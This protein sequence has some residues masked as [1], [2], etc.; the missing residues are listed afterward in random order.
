MRASEAIAAAF[1]EGDGDGEGEGE[2]NGGEGGGEV[3]GGDGDGDGELGEGLQAAGVGVGE[4]E[5]GWLPAKQVS[6]RLCHCTQTNR[7]MVRREG[8]TTG[9]CSQKH[10]AARVQQYGRR[11]RLGKHGA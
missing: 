11:E 6:A 8:A 2:V 9:H 10:I 7:C 5:S 4:K 3:T 1:G